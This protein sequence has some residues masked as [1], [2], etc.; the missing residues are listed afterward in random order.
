[1]DKKT[2]ERNRKGDAKMSMCEQCNVNNTMEHATSTTLKASNMKHGWH[3]TINNT[4]HCYQTPYNIALRVKQLSNYNMLLREQIEMEKD[5][6]TKQNNLS[7]D[8]S[9]HASKLYGS[10]T[11][12]MPKR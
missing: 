6:L 9:R 11:E 3:Q 4:V 10:A 8:E 7:S 5:G 1:M 12:H 2:C